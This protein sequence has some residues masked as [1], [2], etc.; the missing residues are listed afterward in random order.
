MKQHVVAED[1]EDVMA[2]VLLSL[3]RLVEVEPHWQNEC[4]A[5]RASLRTKLDKPENK[6]N[7]EEQ[8]I[9]DAFGALDRLSVAS[10]HL[11]GHVRNFCNTLR[12]LLAR[13]KP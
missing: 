7:H 9:A 3:S 10:P 5:F 6:M 13:P 2:G 8:A 11:Q 4:R 12:R 1:K